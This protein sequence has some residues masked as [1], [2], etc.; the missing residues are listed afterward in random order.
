MAKKKLQDKKT[1]AKERAKEEAKHQARLFAIRRKKA[2]REKEKLERQYR[3]RLEPIRNSIE[4]LEN[5][6]QHLEH[7]L[8]VL[9][10][11]EKEYIAA[12]QQKTN[13]QDELIAEGY[14]TL[15]EKVEALKKKSRAMVAQIAAD[16]QVEAISDKVM[17]ELMLNNDEPKEVEFKNK[18]EKK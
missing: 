7:N 11:L 8:N 6:E 1:K 15:E 17:N 10:A 18:V 16:V 12:Q 9:E 13:L 5:V 14:N 3:N 4:K 2:D